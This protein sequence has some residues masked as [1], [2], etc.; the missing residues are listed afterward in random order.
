MTDKLQ[1]F[2]DT[3]NIVSENLQIDPEEILSKSRK[4]GVVLPRNV[5]IYIMRKHFHFSYPEIARFIGL[6]HTSI[7]NS[8][9]K[10]NKIPFLVAYSDRLFE[11]NIK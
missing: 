11:E 1:E 5:L 4:M 6:K 8:V 2:K 7:I 3:L 10:I 9:Y